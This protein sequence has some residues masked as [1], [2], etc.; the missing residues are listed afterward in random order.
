MLPSLFFP[1]Q[2]SNPTTKIFTF[3]FFT[4]ISEI[5][6]LALSIENS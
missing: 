4:S 3:N 5:N 2:K 1:K 6:L